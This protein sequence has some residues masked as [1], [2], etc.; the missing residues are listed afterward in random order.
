MNKFWIIIGVV[1]LVVIVLFL[2]VSYNYP[3]EREGI[4]NIDWNKCQEVFRLT[5]GSSDRWGRDYA[6]TYWEKM[7]NGLYKMM[8][9][10][11]IGFCVSVEMS[12]DTCVKAYMYTKYGVP[13]P[14]STQF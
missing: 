14:T 2:R 13:A 4:V 1:A 6:C 3:V 10:K 12:G 5:E 7:P 9:D 8:T 11:S